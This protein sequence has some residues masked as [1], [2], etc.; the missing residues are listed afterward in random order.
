VIA[1]PDGNSI[2]SHSSHNG[3]SGS[4]FPGHSP[5]STFWSALDDQAHEKTLGDGLVAPG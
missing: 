4:V 3:A 2:A 1:D 5:C